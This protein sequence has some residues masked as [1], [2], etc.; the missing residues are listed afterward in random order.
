MATG[1]P[2]LQCK[3]GSLHPEESQPLPLATSMPPPVSMH[4]ATPG[5]PETCDFCP[6]VGEH[7]SPSG[8]HD[9]AGVRFPLPS[10]ADSAPVYVLSKDTITHVHCS[11]WL[12]RATRNQGSGH[13]ARAGATG[14]HRAVGV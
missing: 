6:L 7:T 14:R 4:V 11:P 9:V 10:K 8:I 13:S 5:P 1:K 2:V 3:T 12:Y